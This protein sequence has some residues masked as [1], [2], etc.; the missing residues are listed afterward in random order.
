M[1][2]EHEYKDRELRL[3]FADIDRVEQAPLPDRKQAKYEWLADMQINPQ[4]VADRISWLIGGSYGQGSY[5]IAREVAKNTRMNRVSKLGQMIAAL[6]WS[7]SA[8]MARAAWNAMTTGEQ[9]ILSNLIQ[10][11]IDSYLADVK[12]G[13]A[14]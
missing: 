5:I 8:S 9:Q 11:E 1:T 6:E 12:S 3:Y 2:T 10:A 13:E 7:C 14:E 4:L